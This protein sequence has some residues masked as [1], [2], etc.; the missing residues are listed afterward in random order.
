MNRPASGPR[1]HN[2]GGVSVLAVLALL[3]AA[4]TGPGPS[5]G[6]TQSAATAGR[7]PWHTG[8]VSTTFWVGEIF[9]PKAA[10]GSQVMST[11]DSQWMQSYGGCD[12]VVTN[13]CKTEARTQ[14]KGYAPTSM[15][16]KENPFYLDLPYDDVND[17]TAFA[18][19]ASVI[20][21]A[22]DPGFAGNAQNR[23]FS[24]MKNQWVRI[25]MG[26]RECYGQI[27]DAGPGQYHDKNYVFGSN[28]ARP[29]N[30]NFNGAG[31]DVSPAL[32]GCLGFSE[33]DG[34][35]DKVD[36][37]FVPRDQVPAGPWLKIVTSSQVK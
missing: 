25:R 21:W 27:E 37:Q 10:D 6:P 15:T 5:P 3:T 8:I 34:E 33:L 18:E 16:P 28:D 20:P 36:W 17:P 13:G 24:Y 2:R 26:N 4:C 7:Y 23:S 9:D 35:S 31:M 12:G 19:R 30:K 14:A 32:N 22:N 29:V 11:Y 1:R